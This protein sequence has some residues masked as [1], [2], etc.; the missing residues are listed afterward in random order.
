LDKRMALLYAAVE[1]GRI[2]V[3]GWGFDPAVP[4]ALRFAVADGLVRDISTG[5]ELTEA[6]ES[7][8]RDLLK[9]GLLGSEHQKLKQVGTKI[10]QA[11]IDEVARKWEDI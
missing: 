4:I 11:M 5:Y 6:G 3:R 8:A 10:T 7:F 2:E 9:E 1:K